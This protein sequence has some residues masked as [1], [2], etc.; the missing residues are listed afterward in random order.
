MTSI[1]GPL[2]GLYEVWYLNKNRRKYK[3]RVAVQMSLGMIQH[4][5]SRKLMPRYIV[6]SLA[7]ELRERFLISELIFAHPTPHSI[8]EFYYT[9]DDDI[10]MR[11]VDSDPSTNKLVEFPLNVYFAC[12]NTT[13]IHWGKI[14]SNGFFHT[15]NE[16]YPLGFKAVR[17]EFDEVLDCL[18]DCLC[19][20]D[21][22][23]HSSPSKRYSKTEIDNLSFD[24]SDIR[25]LFRI[26]VAWKTGLT[27][28]TKVYEGTTPQ[29]VWKSIKT[30]RVGL[31]E[32]LI[33]EENENV[34]EIDLNLSEFE[35]IDDEERTLR[36]Q[37]MDLRH[38]YQKAINVTKVKK[39][40]FFFFLK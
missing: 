25:P 12:G 4:C 31:S 13:I 39:K 36:D 7:K 10:Q 34:N 6:A 17:Q 16:I 20:I 22:Y 37:L 27:Y 19:E 1:R 40:I 21:C 28:V 2:R 14:I 29:N 5:K 38:R 11:C 9:S 3:T 26:T 18:L 32:N 24:I 8:R 15:R 30:E 35:E 23:S 33:N